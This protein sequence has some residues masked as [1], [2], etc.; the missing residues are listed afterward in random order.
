M[1]Y[2]L[3]PDPNSHP[4]CW[5]SIIEC[6]FRLQIKKKTLCFNALYFAARPEFP[7]AVLVLNNWVFSGC[8]RR[9]RDKMR[10]HIRKRFFKL[11]ILTLSVAVLSVEDPVGCQWVLKSVIFWE[12][13]RT[14]TVAKGISQWQ[15]DKYWAHGWHLVAPSG[16]KTDLSIKVSIF[17]N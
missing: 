13:I 2:T 16:H 5:C 17:G 7:S 10:R 14:K 11:Q 12:L 4:Q 8:A 15:T 3:R 1:H 9:P 6:F